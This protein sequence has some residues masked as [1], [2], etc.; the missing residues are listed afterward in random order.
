MTLTGLMKD[1]VLRFVLN[2]DD[3]A[4]EGWA[5]VALPAGVSPDDATWN[6]TAIVE[7]LST[8]TRDL[9]ARIDEEC[10][11]FRSRFITTIPGQESTYLEKEREARA[12]AAASGP[13]AEDYPMIAA[14]AG[15]RGISINAQ[16]ALVVATANVWRP[17]AAAIEAARM[18]AKEAVKAAPSRAAKLAAAAVDW[19]AL[20]P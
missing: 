7:D 11:A 12:W 2:P 5:Q 6:G 18:G 13:D 19:E 4:Q 3:E 8:L 10:G 15:A 16:A 20:V 17:L 14:E 9:L 1:G